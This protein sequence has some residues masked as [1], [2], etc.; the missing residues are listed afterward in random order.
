MKGG[1]REHYSQYISGLELA[2]VPGTRQDSE[3]HLRHPLILRFLVLTG[4]RRAQ[5]M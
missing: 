5:S 2:R 3:H 1:G 4:T